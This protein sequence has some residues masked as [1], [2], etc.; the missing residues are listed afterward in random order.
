MIVNKLSSYIKITKGKH[1]QHTLVLMSL[2]H[3][4]Y[5]SINDCPRKCN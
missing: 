5:Y 2:S 1:E 3:V 4:N